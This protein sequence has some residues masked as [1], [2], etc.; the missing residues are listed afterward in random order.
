[1]DPDENYPVYISEPLVVLSLSSLFEK[2]SWRMRRT[3]ISNSFRNARYDSSLGFVFEEVALVLMEIFGGK[4]NCLADAFRC[5]EPL[6]S[7]RVTIVSLMR[8]ADGVMQSNP[9]SWKAGSSDRFGL[10]ANPPADVL[11]LL[12]RSRW[13][14]L[15]V[16]GWPHGP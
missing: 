10:K 7:R 5:S 2:Q 1:L 13:K 14:D 4:V 12:A 8:G 15:S 6:G 16:Y 9:A 11:S 3:W